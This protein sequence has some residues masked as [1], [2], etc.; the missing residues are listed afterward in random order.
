MLV[1]LFGKVDNTV[2][3]SNIFE[4]DNSKSEEDNDDDDDD[5]GPQR[6]SSTKIAKTSGAL[7]SSDSGRLA[8]KKRS[9]SAQV[10]ENK[11]NCTGEA[12]ARHEAGAKMSC[13]G[14]AAER[15]KPSAEC[16]ERVQLNSQPSIT[17]GQSPERRSC[18]SF[19]TTRL[20]RRI[21]MSRRS[22]L[23]FALLSLCCLASRCLAITNIA[24]ADLPPPPPMFENNNNHNQQQQQQVAS[25][26]VD[27][28]RGPLS[29]IDWPRIG[30]SLA[31]QL[32]AS[33]SNFVA[34]RA[35]Q[36][37]TMPSRN[38][39]V[40]LAPTSTAATSHSLLAAASAAVPSRRPLFNFWDSSSRA[41]SP[42]G[43]A[44]PSAGRWLERLWSRLGARNSIRVDNAFRDLAWRIL[45][46]LSMPTP[47]IYE[48][49]R[50]HLYSPDEDWANDRLFSRNTSKTIRSQRA[51][52]SKRSLDNGAIASDDVTSPKASNARRA[53]RDS[54]DD[55]LER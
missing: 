7:L 37:N 47:V 48:L 17:I 43:Q 38:R 21:P 42:S 31:A 29:S 50:Q 27:S 26:R 55:E 13:S 10:G 5:Y 8:H 36:S 18:G 16:C 49:R 6:N 9:A 24:T 45:G 25:D 53:A 12:S 19:T 34:T 52:F 14:V 41:P 2:A 46:S 20:V 51:Q 30:A 32:G 35:P 1:M 40:S 44:R 22:S 39:W 3:E 4:E 54:D 15:L 28:A 23:C 11:E 33:G